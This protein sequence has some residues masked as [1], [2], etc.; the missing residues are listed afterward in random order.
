[1]FLLIFVWSVITHLLS[2]L[3]LS[4][5]LCPTVCE[6]L[7]VRDAGVRLMTTL[8][9]CPGN[10][11]KASQVCFY[12]LKASVNPLYL[13]LHRCYITLKWLN[14]YYPTFKN[15]WKSYERLKCLIDVDVV[16]FPFCSAAFLALLCGHSALCWLWEGHTC[17][18]IMYSKRGEETYFMKQ[19]CAY[20]FLYN[21]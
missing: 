19:L 2:V 7:S 10:A 17:G 3:V 15:K 14:L 20:V 5:C 16:R 13:Q 6:E 1:M 9:L 12:Y 4:D 11:P 18:E 8:T 21:F